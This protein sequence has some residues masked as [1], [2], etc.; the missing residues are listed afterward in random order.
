MKEIKLD[1]NTQ[2]KV[3]QMDIEKVSLTKPIDLHQSDHTVLFRHFVVYLL[4]I[5]IQQYLQL[6]SSNTKDITFR[7]CF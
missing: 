2:Q 6:K 5:A 1:S 7:K 4:H 3:K